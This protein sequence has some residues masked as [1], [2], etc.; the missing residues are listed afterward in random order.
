MNDYEIVLRGLE[1]MLRPFRD[2]I[3]VV[4][5]DVE[6]NPTKRSTSRC[7]IPTGIRAWA[8]IVSRTSRTIPT[9]T[10][11]PCTRGRSRRSASTPP[12]R[13]APAA[14][15]RSRCRPKRSSTR[16]SRSR[17]EEE[18]VERA[19]RTIRAPTVAGLRPRPDV[20]R[21]RGRVRSSRKAC[22]TVNRECALGEREHGEDPSQVHLPEDGRQ[23]AGRGHRA[24]HTRH[25]LQPP[26]CGAP[27]RVEPTS[28]LA[29]GTHPEAVT[30]PIGGPKCLYL[31]DGASRIVCR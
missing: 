9:C 29:T 23:L 10:R 11:S 16:S 2:R 26:A 22:A 3:E 30:W 8:S 28:L 24:H 25:E 20:A 7:S 21:E 18:F 31:V 12:G 15:S 5:L 27:G 17:R 13:P 1:A 4:E 14:C 19:L 6:H